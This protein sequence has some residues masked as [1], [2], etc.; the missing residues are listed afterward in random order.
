MQERER[1]QSQQAQTAPS[2]GQESV[3]IDSHLARHVEG[4]V[5]RQLDSL[6]FT[7]KMWGEVGEFQQ[8]LKIHH[9]VA[10]GTMVFLGVMMMWYGTWGL[11]AMIPVLKSPAVALTTGVA[12]LALTGVL[13]SKLTG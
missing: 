2:E 4:E 8:G 7:R 1:R 10:Y 3:S 5:A 12:L 9:K 13:Y 11:V 6:N